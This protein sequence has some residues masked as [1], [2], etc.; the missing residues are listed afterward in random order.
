M[1]AL[2]YLLKM[3]VIQNLKLV[4]LAKE[5]WDYLLQ[6]GIT[7]TAEYLPTKLDVTAD[8]ESRDI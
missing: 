2:T 7:F 5:I 8:W 6:Y 4:Q 3:R 1:V